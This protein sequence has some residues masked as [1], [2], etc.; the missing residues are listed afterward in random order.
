MTHYK[1]TP[2]G[3]VP[4]TPE[5]ESE[6]DLMEVEYAAG[7]DDRAAERR[8]SM[9]CT[10]RQARLALVT[11]GVYES[12]Q[13]AV[14]SVSDQAR[15]E[16]EYATMIERNNPIIAEMQEALGMSDEDLDALFELA[17]TL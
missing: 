17:V 7:A 2:N 15:I 13:T 1:A 16:W 9:A 3:T 5:E 11:A 4:F 6:W 12:V 14:T 8:A 10:P